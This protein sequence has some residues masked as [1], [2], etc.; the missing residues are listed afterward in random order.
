MTSSRHDGPGAYPLVPTI[1]S[2][3][4]CFC[5]LVT[6]AT[7]IASTPAK[8]LITGESGVGK[9]LIARLIHS[10]SSRA[11]GPFVAVHCPGVSET[12]L[13][14]ELFGHVK[15]SFTGAYRDKVGRLERAHRGTVFLDEIGD[16]SPR[17]QALLLRFLETGEIQPVGSDRPSPYVD[18]RVISAT[19]RD[20][21]GDVLAGAFREDLFYRINGIH[22][23]VPP[24][25]ERVEDIRPLVAHFLAT[26]GGSVTLDEDMLQL[27][28]RYRWPGNVRELQNTVEQ[29]ASVIDSGTA[30]PGDL[31]LALRTAQPGHLA[32]SRDRRRA[33][34]DDLYEGLVSGGCRFWEDVYVLFMKR[35]ITRADVRKV[36]ER[37]L[38]ASS[39]SYRRLLQLF[40]MDQQEYK[41]LLN[42]LA[43]HEC[44][45]DPKV[46]LA[47]PPAPSG[48]AAPRARTAS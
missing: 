1:V 43:A 36:I 31:P 15:G 45:V 46:R 6:F 28:E 11:A 37:G 27:F 40:G 33:I 9:D 39:G 7:R 22:L 32:L 3:S 19:N 8:V 48:S 47:P 44:R 24:L 14:S 41:R 10:S 4:P 42:F 30:R 26:R 35:D 25:R 13:E 16:M 5:E 20:L 23:K 2:A 29:I 12:L 38:V 18:V 21:H 34:A 17:M